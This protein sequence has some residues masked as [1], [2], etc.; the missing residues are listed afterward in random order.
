[1]EPS[2][3]HEPDTVAL[4]ISLTLG[5]EKHENQKFKVIFRY[6]VKFKVSLGLRCEYIGVREMALR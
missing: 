3:P 6:I 2:E 1:M 5:G 4:P